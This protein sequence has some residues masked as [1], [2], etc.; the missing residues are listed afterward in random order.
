MRR[1]KK[2]FLFS[3]LSVLFLGSFLFLSFAFAQGDLFGLQPVDD[4]IG[5]GGQD[6]RLTIARIIRALLSLLGIIAVGIMLY[7]GFVYMTAGGNEEKIGTAKKILINGVIGLV[8][9]LSSFSIAQ[10]IINQLGKATG[11]IS[12][13]KPPQCQNDDYAQANKCQCYDFDCSGE[14]SCKIGLDE[15]DYFVVKSITPVTKGTGMNNVVIRV[16]FNKNVAEKFA[17]E[18]VFDIKYKT[19]SV[20]SSFHFEFF[21]DGTGR[22]ILEAVSTD[23]FCLDE[24][25]NKNI[26]CLDFGGYRVEVRPDLESEEGHLLKEETD[27]GTFPVKAEFKVG[28]KDGSE[29]LSYLDF[30]GIDGRV[31]INGTSTADFVDVFSMSFWVYIDEQPGDWANRYIIDNF[32]GGNPGSGYLINYGKNDNSLNF[33]VRRDNPTLYEEEEKADQKSLSYTVEEKK[34]MHVSTVFAGDSMSMYV[35]GE[36]VGNL[37]LPDNYPLYKYGGKLVFGGEQSAAND[38]YS[39]KGKLDEVRIYEKVLSPQ[40]ILELSQSRESSNYDGLYAGYH[41]EEG[42]G[43]DVNDLFDG[44]YHGEI[45]GGVDWIAPDWGQKTIDKEVPEFLDGLSLVGVEDGGF[46]QSGKTYWASSTIA[47]N[48]G[49]GGYNIQLV[50]DANSEDEEILISYFDGPRIKDGSD[51]PPEKPFEFLYPIFT[52]FNIEKKTHYTLILDALDIDSNF[53]Q[54]IKEYDLLPDHCFNDVKDEDE[55]GVDSGGSCGGDEGDSC[56][57]DWQC[58]D[59]N[60]CVDNICT[61]WPKILDVDPMHG[62]TGNWV[63]IFGKNFG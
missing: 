19:Q 12:D 33:S 31:Y 22:Q 42:E 62:A 21:G 58:S 1:Q 41:F 39:F 15:K 50:K 60:K 25:T 59:G 18:E 44:E 28:G 43:A 57:E 40:E 35:D 6:I 49:L 27:C 36:L 14:E 54:I 20:S 46:L 63:S 56:A 38:E 13:G 30:D 51:A 34:W 2:I 7:G 16:I 17:S 23:E 53:S 55:T 47:D 52:S 4:T 26:S 9:I 24:E 61:A 29:E 37:D 3:F 10:F 48:S 5:L 32:T 45:S 8:I 11:A